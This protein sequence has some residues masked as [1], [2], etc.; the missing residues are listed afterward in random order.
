MLQSETQVDTPLA[1]SYLFKLCKHFARKI[2]VEFDETT[3][4]AYFPY[5]TCHF[6]ASATGLTFVLAASD[7]NQIEQLQQVIEHHLQLMRRAPD[8]ALHWLP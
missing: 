4:L 5:G 2:R 6:T 7:D 1:K 8:P 3:G